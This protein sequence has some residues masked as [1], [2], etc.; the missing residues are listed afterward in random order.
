M[1]TVIRAARRPWAWGLLLLIFLVPAFSSAPAEAGDWKDKMRGWG[2][3]ARGAV[4]R[5]REAVRERAP[6]FKKR[7]SEGTKRL[8]DGASRAGRAIREKAPEY[9]KK[10]QETWKRAQPRIREG[11]R[12][13]RQDYVPRARE[14]GR[15]T[16]AKLKDLSRHVTP[17]RMARLRNDL[18]GAVDK[19]GPLMKTRMISLYENGREH[20]LP[21]ARELMDHCGHAMDKTIRD[22]TFRARAMDGM[23][24]ALD[25]YERYDKV[26]DHAIRQGLDIIGNRI[27]IKVDGKW[28]TFNKAAGS[29]VA[30]ACPALGDTSISREPVQAVV[31]TLIAPEPSYIVNELRVLKDGRG[32]ALSVGE[33]LESTSGVDANG[34]VELMEIGGGLMDLRSS[35]RSGEGVVGAAAGLANSARRYGDSRAASIVIHVDVSEQ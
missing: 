22:P 34:L 12:R 29:M 33:A 24:T 35:L 16:Q 5:G 26:K 13:V 9:K 14:F 18:T 17:E 31:Y 8:R 6:T 28:T 27:P 3:K 30:E 10:A 4:E 1:G 21:K 11:V 19:Y 2:K 20:L 23:V 15:A 25:V 32:N 7:V